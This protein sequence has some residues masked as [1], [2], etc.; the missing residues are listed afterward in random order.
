MTKQF[1]IDDILSKEEFIEPPSPITE[2]KK[3]FVVYQE[4]RIQLMLEVSEKGGQL[5]ACNAIFEILNDETTTEDSK[6]K[7]LEQYVADVK[8]EFTALAVKFLK[9]GED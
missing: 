1:D 4:D 5:A 8:S 6:S 7:L 9:T 3:E 2:F